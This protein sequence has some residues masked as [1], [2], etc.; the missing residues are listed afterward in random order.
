MNKGTAIVGFLLCFLAGMGLMWGIDRGAVGGGTHATA[1][2]DNPAEWSDEG[3]S[4]PISSKDPTWGNRN[5]P[6]TIVLFSDYECP[7]CTKVETTFTALKQKYGPQQLRIV[8]KDNPLPFHKRAIPAAVAGQA[9]F[10]LGGNDAF[11]KFHEKAFANQKALTDENFALWAKEAGVDPAK[12]KAAYD[13][14]EGKAKVDADMAVGKAGGVK[15]TPASFVN[16]VFLSGAQPQPKFEAAIDEQL[17]AAKAKIAAGTPADKVYVTLS[18]ENKAKGPPA[19]ADGKD[20]KDPK[21]PKEDD[22]TIY[23][24][25]AGD[26]PYK[27]AA[28]ALVTIIEFSDF[29][30]P[31]CSRVNPTISTILKDY[32]GK[33][34]VVWKHRPLP[35]HKRAPAASNLTIEAYK[36]KGPDAFWKAHDLLFANQK[37]LEDAD[38]E[39]Y[40]GELGLDVEKAKEAFTKNKYGD[41]IAA[42]NELADEVEAGGTPHFFI[43]GRRLSGAQPVD[44][45]KKV[46][47]EQLKVAEALLAKGVAKKDIYETLQKEA[48]EAAPPEK[49]DVG[50]VPA[51]A[52]WKGGEKAKVTIQIFSDYECPFC[53]RVEGTLGQV[54]KEF[55]EK[56]KFVWRDNPL[57]MHKNAVAAANAAREAQKQKGNKG[58]WSMHHA[59]FEAAGKPD[60][61]VPD[62]L[63]S[64][65]EKEGLDVGKVKAAIEGNTYKALV[66]AD[67][68]AAKKAGISGAPAFSINGYFIS[69]AQPFSKF[70]KVINLALK[71]AGGGAAAPAAAPAAPGGEKKKAPA[72]PGGSPYP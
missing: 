40:A 26:S 15:G 65:A 3:A 6:V 35:F 50:P 51:D 64:I 16:G 1:A 57:A 54:E 8:W 46:I 10:A 48:K 9:V 58:F 30:C 43:N 67:L 60:A 36:Q 28:D 53:K 61:L 49:K 18:N 47:D 27:G 37:A 63:V 45:F 29:Q 55:G 56:V 11:W 2:N 17:A 44:A 70:K 34:R 71:E 59:L 39:K 7:F 42:D 23:R 24:V 21:K 5:A 22:K 14:Q 19:A 41:I 4:I 20:A 38:L 72:A 66:D 62:N 69:G 13:K 52:P 12:F 33:V 31:F 68:E 32:E 25:P